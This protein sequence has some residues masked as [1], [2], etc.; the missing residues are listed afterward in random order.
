MPCRRF[1]VSGRVQGVWFRA[2]TRQQAVRLG[3]T[4]SADNL[5]DGRVVV[6]A[7]GDG[8]ALTALERWL[9]QGPEL[10]QVSA[11]EAVDIPSQTFTGFSTGNA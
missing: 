6:L 9:W 10:A 7:C 4:G 11:V 3:L 1:V 5:A 2:S 8:A